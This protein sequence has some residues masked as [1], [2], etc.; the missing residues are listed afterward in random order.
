[1]SEVRE[2]EVKQAPWFSLDQYHGKGVIYRDDD[3]RRRCSSVEQTETLTSLVR[4]V[5]IES[6]LLSKGGCQMDRFVVFV[7]LIVLCVT[8]KRVPEDTAHKVMVDETSQ[9]KCVWNEEGKGSGHNP[10]KY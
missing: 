9:G 2:E 6:L 4:T 3:Y 7:A 5:G 8:E 1:M 10:E